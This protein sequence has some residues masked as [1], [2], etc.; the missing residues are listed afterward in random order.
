M[1]V[2]TR[3][4]TRAAL[5]WAVSAVEGVEC[6]ENHQPI[7]FDEDG[8]LAPR[9]PYLPSSN[10]AQGVPIIDRQ[11]ISLSSPQGQPDSDWVATRGRVWARGPTSLIAAMRCHVASAMGD[12]I[13]IPEELL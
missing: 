1:K 5:D 6:D 2:K 11:W 7:W 10:G 13:D 3:E 12:E 8:P 4:L 9:V